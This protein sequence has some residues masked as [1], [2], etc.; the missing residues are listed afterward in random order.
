[1]QKKRKTKKW[2]ERNCI[3]KKSPNDDENEK[4]NLRYGKKGYDVSGLD[5]KS[6][7]SFI[8]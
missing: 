8:G 5:R 1:M 6:C 2:R 3:K 7:V 4:C